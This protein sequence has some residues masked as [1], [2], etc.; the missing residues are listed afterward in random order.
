MKSCRG[1][2]RPQREC[3]LIWGR[4]KHHVYMISS[5][6]RRFICTVIIISSMLTLEREAECPAW[7]RDN[8]SCLLS[9]LTQSRQLLAC[10]SVWKLER[11][12]MGEL[13]PLR[14]SGCYEVCWGTTSNLFSSLRWPWVLSED[15]ERFVETKEDLALSRHVLAELNVGAFRS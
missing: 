6:M 15:T 2:R 4:Q 14:S 11:V 5:K 3:S 10:F 13:F 7:I 1:V 12:G 8:L 9:Y